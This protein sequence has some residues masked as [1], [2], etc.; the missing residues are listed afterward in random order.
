[1]D[2]RVC[3]VT[4]ANS[5]IGKAASIALAGLGASI[6]LVCRNR[7][8]GESALAEVGAAAT[9]GQPSLELADLSSMEQ[10]RNLAAR[11]DRLA[12]VDVLVNNAG[13][14]VA[15]RRLTA[16]GFEHTLAVNHLAPFLLTNLLRPKLEA[17]APARVITVASI[18]HRA[19]L[20]NLDDLQ[21]E[22]HY[23][24]MLAYSNSKLAN[25]LFTRE[26]ARRLT[27]TK[28]TANALHPGTVAT[29]FGQ[30]GNRWLKYGLAVGRHFLRTP[31]SGARTVVYLAS[32]P[33]VAGQTGG[34]YVGRRRRQPSTAARDD[35]LARRLWEISARLTGLDRPASSC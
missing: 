14:V 5:G 35:D 25:I 10:V 2:G 29:N 17:S 15:S 26:L 31:Q 4:G 12:R 33:D 24:A 19:A 28:V 27:E 11:L 13:L 6:V 16:D 23:L 34:Y 9:G 30:T 32:S 18:A 1:M 22:H 21:L 3:V 8:R 7:G 20:L